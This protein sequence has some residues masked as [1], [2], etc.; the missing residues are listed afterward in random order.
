MNSNGTNI[1]I[2][3]V[4]IAFISAQIFEEFG[5]LIRL[6]VFKCPRNKIIVKFNRFY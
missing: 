2:T 3:I 4:F 1:I 5:Y 6:A